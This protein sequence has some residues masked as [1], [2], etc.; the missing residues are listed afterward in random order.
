MLQQQKKQKASLYLIK[1]TQKYTYSLYPFSVK[2]K[3]NINYVVRWVTQKVTEINEN[4]F[5]PKW[6]LLD[7]MFIFNTIQL[8]ITLH[9]GLTEIIFSLTKYMY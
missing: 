1:K 7:E 4:L 2:Q 3:I 6:Y 9:K 5:K 8:N